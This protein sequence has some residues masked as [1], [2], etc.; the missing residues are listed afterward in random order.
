[1]ENTILR[2]QFVFRERWQLEGFEAIPPQVFYLEGIAYLRSG[3]PD[4]GVD[5]L[6]VCLLVDEDH[7]LAHYNL[8]VVLLGQGEVA[9]SRAHLD[10]ALAAGVVPH[11]Q[12][13]ADLELAQQRLLIE[14]PPDQEQSSLGRVQR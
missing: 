1:M 10:A 12:F 14:R 3:R 9:E 6:K 4:L 13:V 7:G 11:A 2:E 8:A 5:A